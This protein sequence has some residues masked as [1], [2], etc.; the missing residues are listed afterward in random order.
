VNLQILEEAEK[1]LDKA[2]GHHEEIE[3]GLGLRP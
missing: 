2:V 1:E 3:S